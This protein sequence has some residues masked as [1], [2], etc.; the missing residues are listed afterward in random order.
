MAEKSSS[1]G[2]PPAV[3]SKL[4]LFSLAMLVLPL[5]AYY[6]SLEYLFQGYKTTHA[7]ITA[8]VV[9][10][11]VLVGYVIAAFLEDDSVV[12]TRPVSSTATKKRQ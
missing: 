8:A 2:V 3:L 6:L 10:N 11:L 5:S 4:L 7:A 1:Q 12:Q 9:A